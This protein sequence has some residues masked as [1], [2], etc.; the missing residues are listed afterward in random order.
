MAE[1]GKPFVSM[2]FPEH[3]E[4]AAVAL[5]RA[6]INDPTFRP[7]IPD[8]NDP[9]ERVRCLTEMFRALLM[10]ERHTGQPTF[11]VFVDGRVV[12]AAITEGRHIPSVPN[13]IT[14]G[15]G[16]MPALLRGIGVGGI[17]RSLSLVSVL[18]N[19]HPKQ[20]HLYLQVLGVDPAYQKR[21]LGAALLDH[22]RME[23][24]A[25]P[26]VEGVYLE[27]ATEANVGYYSSKGYEILGEIY[28]LG[29]KMWRMF[30]RK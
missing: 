6:F 3:H 15:I 29:V 25:R 28:P 2:L 24:I 20:P 26:D 8:V 11:G 23:A 21:H 30:Q 13:M 4:E 19:A 12:A 16:A 18:T 17:Y 10:I 1:N 27:T 9:V 5:G 14:S 7:L 22:L